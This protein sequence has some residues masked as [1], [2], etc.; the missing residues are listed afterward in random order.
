MVIIE[1]RMGVNKLARVPVRLKQ[2]KKEFSL[3]CH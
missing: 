1:A 2:K 3:E